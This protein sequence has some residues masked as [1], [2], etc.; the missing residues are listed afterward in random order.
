MRLIPVNG[1]IIISPIAAEN[2]IGKL[3][4]P[5]P[6]EDRRPEQGTIVS[7]AKD[8]ELDLKKGDLVLFDKYN[9][10]VYTVSNKKYMIVSS[11]DVH[12]LVR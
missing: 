10:D 8:V 11:S 5:E 4:L 6:K 9:A 7:M 12:A 1:K 2:K 3:T